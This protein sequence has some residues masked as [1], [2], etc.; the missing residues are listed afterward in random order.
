MLGFF[1]IVHDTLICNQKF[2]FKNTLIALIPE[3]Q[4]VILDLVKQSLPIHVKQVLHSG[5]SLRYR[6]QSSCL[7]CVL[8][9]L[10]I[11]FIAL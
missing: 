10:E 7:E 9:R 1:E 11:K 3:I 2:S 4:K 6:L 5:M 8:A